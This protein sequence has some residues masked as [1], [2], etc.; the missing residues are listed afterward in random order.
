MA[1]KA[2]AKK[3]SR[4]VT[5]MW[6]GRFTTVHALMAL[7]VMFNLALLVVLI[8]LA[9]GDVFEDLYVNQGL[10]T[11]CS[12]TYRDKQSTDAQALINY[13]CAGDGAHDF[14]LQGYNDYR[15]T[16]NLEPVKE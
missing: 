8:L 14:F 6:P 11:Y 10:S 4:R 5:D 2:K 12:D 1:T 13:R 7:S 15:K 16:L 3:S 9:R